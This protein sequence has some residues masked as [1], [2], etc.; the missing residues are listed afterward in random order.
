VPL[1][2]S[3]FRL[4]RTSVG[5]ATIGVIDTNYADGYQLPT[6]ERVGGGNA[7]VA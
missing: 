4:R 6:E 2:L 1:P 5:G 7:G 3:E